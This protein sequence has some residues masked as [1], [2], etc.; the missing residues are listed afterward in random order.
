M[1]AG[2]VFAPMHWT[3]QF[4][5]SGPVDR[6]VHAVTDPVSGQPDLK[7][8]SVQVE[9]VAET[10]RG[11]L[12]RRAAVDPD[13]GESVHWSKTPIAAGFAYELSGQ[14]PLAELVDSVRALRSLL[15]TPEEAELISYADPKRSVFR[16]AGL[17]DG[18][19]EACVFFAAPRASFPEAGKAAHLLGQV[20][21][22]IA[23]LSL[24]AGVEV[25]AAPS[26]DIVCSCFSV[27]EAAIRSA[28]RKEKLAS[29]AEVGA[30]LKAGTHCGSCIPELKKLLS[31]DAAQLSKVA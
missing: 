15:Q 3:D 1:R 4:S 20:L 22:P 12:F 23:R 5:S 29:A 9:A 8:T 19:L 24:L 25:G 26:G 10:W 13:L 6:L 18:R 31:A 16:Y 27:G 28:I 7:G 30:V 17:F 14:T 2:D 21:D 11:L